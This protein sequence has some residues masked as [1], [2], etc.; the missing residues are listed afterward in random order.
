MTPTTNMLIKNLAQNVPLSGNLP[1][2]IFVGVVGPLI[3]AQGAAFY[4]V[5]KYSSRETIIREV[6]YMFNSDQR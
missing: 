6:N 1:L 3:T 4:P 5:S 2:P